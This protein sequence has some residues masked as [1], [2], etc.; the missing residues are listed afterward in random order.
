MNKF[1]LVAPMY[2]A[3]T[4]LEQMLLSVVAQSYK[5]WK[6]ILVDDMSNADELNKCKSIIEKINS[7]FEYN[8]SSKILLLENESKKW[9]VENVLNCISYCNDEDIVCR[10]DPDDYLCDLNALELLNHSYTSDP[11]IEAIW[12]AHRWFDENGITMNNISN[13]MPYLIDVYKHP[14]VSSHF[15]TFRKKVINSIN[16]KNFRGKDGEYI[17]RA[18][19]QAIYLPILQKCK[20]YGFLPIM[21]YAYRCNMSKE[22]F[23]SE[24]AIFQKKEGEFIRSRGFV[25]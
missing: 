17:K 7:Y 9:E 14:W 10:L 8:D 12:T 13:N 11:E 6:I 2:N 1:V 3:S 18:G 25:E 19:D 15:K 5:N 23:Q 4:T 20:K 22:T 24:D 21:T 16:D